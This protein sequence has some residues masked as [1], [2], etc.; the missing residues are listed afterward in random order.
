MN[1]IHT[2]TQ[3]F[4]LISLQ[5]DKEVGNLF[6]IFHEISTRMGIKRYMLPVPVPDGSAVKNLPAMQ[7][8]E[9]MQVQT[10]GQ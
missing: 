7:E 9:E 6:L 1:H 4:L 10:L 5:V 2:H 8:L 3:K